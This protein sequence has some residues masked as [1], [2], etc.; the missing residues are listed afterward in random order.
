MER[1]LKKDAHKQAQTEQIGI[2]TQVSSAQTL[3]NIQEHQENLEKHD[4][5]KETSVTSP[6][7]MDICELSDREFKIAVWR[8]LIKL[9][10]DTKKKFRIISEKFNRL[11]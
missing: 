4:L 5:T 2:N 11:K 8:K 1:P 9:Q 7:V 3:T 6:R 10:N